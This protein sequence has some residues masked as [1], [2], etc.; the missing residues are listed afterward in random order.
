MNR[1]N[2]DSTPLVENTTLSLPANLQQTIFDY[3]P[4]PVPMTPVLEEMARCYRSGEWTKTPQHYAPLQ[5]ACFLQPKSP[6]HHNKRRDTFRARAD[7]AEADGFVV[8]ENFRVLME[9]DAYVD[10]LHHNTI[11]IEMPEQLW[12]LPSDPSRV[13]FLAFVEGHAGCGWH[14]LL[15]PDG[16]HVMVFCNNPFGLPSNWPG[17]KVPDYSQW[18]VEQCADSIEEWLYH[19]FVDSAEH[20]RKYL[21][22]LR[23]FIADRWNG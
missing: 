20:D 21:K 22:H 4:P 10:R 2:W 19:Y 12:R 18:Q 1:V 5:A 15:A 17:R 14:L 6:A 3:L 9:T 7:E 16:S 8:P 11:W 23:P 13:V